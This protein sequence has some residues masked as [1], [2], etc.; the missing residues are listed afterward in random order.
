MLVYGYTCYTL[1]MKTM[2]V[3]DI[4]HK[5]PEVEASLEVEGEIVITR[6]S[7]PIAKLVRYEEKPEEKE[8]FDFDN[9][10]AWIEKIGRENP[11]AVK[12]FDEDLQSSREDRKL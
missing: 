2:T 1:I 11:E 6:N 5:W 3:R 4:R 10:V 9:H 12:S 8:V 7:T